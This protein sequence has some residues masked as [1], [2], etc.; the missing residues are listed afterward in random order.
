MGTALLNTVAATATAGYITA[1]GVR[2]VSAGLVHGYAIAF[3]VGAVFLVIAALVAAVFV[4]DK[5]VN[6][7][8]LDV[9]PVLATE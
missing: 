3:A 2:S 8:V 4:T 5:S 6:Q 1:H 9:N 7:P